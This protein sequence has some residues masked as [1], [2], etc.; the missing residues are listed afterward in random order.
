[1]DPMLGG[2]RGSMAEILHCR[3]NK[4]NEKSTRYETVRSI[5]S[6]AAD[7]IVQ[8]RFPAVL[9]QVIIRDEPIKRCQL[10]IT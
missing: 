2:I 3:V 7:P 5:L 6:I 8:F 9:G 4:L 1:M 10:S